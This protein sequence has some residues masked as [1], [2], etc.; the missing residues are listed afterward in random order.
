MR[1]RPMTMRPSAAREV[2]RPFA[3][4][5]SLPADVNDA[6]EAYKLCILRHRLSGWQEISCDDMLASLDALKQ[7][8]LSP[9][10][11]S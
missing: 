4:L 8:A 9:A 2:V 1:V 11:V 3:H 7:L 6:F 5:A 10:E